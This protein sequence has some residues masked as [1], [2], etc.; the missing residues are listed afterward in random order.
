MQFCSLGFFILFLVC[1]SSYGHA[2]IVGGSAYLQGDHLEVGIAECGAYGTPNGPPAIGAAG[3]PYH[4]TEFGLGF[5]AD[6]DMDGWTVGSPQYCG[7]YFLPGSPV[8]GWTMSVGGIRYTNASGFGICGSED[9]PGTL[10]G[11]TDGDTL[12][13]TWEGSSAGGFDVQIRTHFP[14]EKR[15][16]LG[17]V[18]ITNTSAATLTDIYWSRQVD[19][20]NDQAWGGGFPT[21]NEIVSQPGFGSSDALVTARGGTFGC[22]LGLGA[23]HFASRV[24]RGGFFVMGPEDPYCAASPYEHDG[25]LTG[26]DAIAVTFFFERLEAGESLSFTYAYILDS[27]ELEEA[28]DA[29][30]AP[31]VVADGL[32]LEAGSSG[33]PEIEICAGDSVLLEIQGG[34]NFSWNWAPF[35]AFSNP[36][37]TS[38]WLSAN[39]SG[40][41]AVTMP[42]PCGDDLRYEFRLVVDDPASVLNPVDTAVCPGTSL[43]LNNIEVAGLDVSWTPALL[44]DNINSQMPFVQVDTAD[45]ELSWEVTVSGPTGCTVKDSAR[46]LVYPEPDISAGPD[47]TVPLGEG[48]TLQGSGAVGYMWTPMGPLDDPESATPTALSVDT[49]TF[50][51][52]AWDE[53]G[54]V[55]NDQV[56]VFPYAVGEFTMPNAFTPNGDGM[57]DCFRTKLGQEVQFSD[58]RIFNRWGTTVFASSDPFACWDG[59]F[60]G[61]PQAIGS[62]IV[63]VNL[64]TPEGPTEYAGTLTLLR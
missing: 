54:C 51:L 46:I 61:E 6:A 29:T 55:V 60:R 53:N 14:K 32:P 47:Q 28:L 42:V 5:V 23:R 33:L 15:Y 50:Q 44:I 10:V 30:S 2:Q 1:L 11:Y 62:Y 16:F 41:Y 52:T 9:I 45:V 22:F 3:T 57:H 24:S 38:T 56:T 63:V 27:D 48:V 40:T 25:M 7:D 19:P 35:T 18:T 59:T 43:L 4:P 8:E 36:A 64:R 20:D 12:S 39:E 34:D 37:G 49:Q 31:V 21:E 58:I 17:E 13:A 26:D